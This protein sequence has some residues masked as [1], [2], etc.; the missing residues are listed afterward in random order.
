MNSGKTSGENFII[1]D[2]LHLEE[3]L[4]SNY[5]VQNYKYVSIYEL[6]DLSNYRN[7]NKTNC[8]ITHLSS[9]SLWQS[10]EN[11]IVKSKQT[12]D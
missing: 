9:S 7:V 8:D 1:I 6:L 10:S 5:S 12:S 11:F 3:K 2:Q 4:V